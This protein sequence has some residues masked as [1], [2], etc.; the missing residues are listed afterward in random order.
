MTYFDY[1]ATT[2]MSSEAFDIYKKV[3]QRH[4][5]NIQNNPDSL[6]LSNQAKQELLAS[7]N[8][9]PAY[10]VIYTSGGTESN[11]LGIIGKYKN[12]SSQK[13]FI[14]TTIE[15]PSVLASFHELERLGHL[16][17]YLTPNV[18]GYL[19][20]QILL[21]SIKKNTA[22]IAIMAVNN[23]LGC[24]LNY[25]ELFSSVRKFNPKI[26]LFCDT[27]AAIGKIKIDLTNIDM[28][29]I[30]AHKIHGPKGVGAL[31]KKKNIVLDPLL[32]GSS[33]ALR[34]GTQ[35][36]GAQIAFVKQIK[37]ATNSLKENIAKLNIHRQLLLQKLNE[38]SGVIINSNPQVNII[39]CSL[40]TTILAEPTITLLRQK[41]FILST[42]SACST[43]IKH[44]H[45]LKALNIAIPVMERTIR[46]SFDPQTSELEIKSLIKELK[47]IIEN[48]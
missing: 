11:N 7:F 45:V 15:H 1:A 37:T 26:L 12:S 36:L 47:F 39:S 43:K 22:L 23:E 24:I 46:I 3:S 21:N 19:K 6:T 40:P 32:F 16:V 8:L 33:G 41:G 44:S 13:H 10:E 48:Y 25:A 9:T 35:S 42:K 28:F 17:T 20:P 38:M 27:I 14:T 31:I 30:S 34:P 29:T 4:F 2:Q 18:S 5:A